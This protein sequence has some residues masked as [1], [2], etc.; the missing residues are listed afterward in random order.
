[1]PENPSHLACYNGSHPERTG[2]QLAV[3]R[4]VDHEV[5]RVVD[6]GVLEEIPGVYA[7][8]FCLTI[9]LWLLRGYELNE[10]RMRS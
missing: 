4:S 9:L 3:E 1:M 10:T 8:P 6:I 7:A 5:P 2:C